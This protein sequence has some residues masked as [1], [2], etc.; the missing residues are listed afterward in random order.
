MKKSVTIFKIRLLYIMVVVAVLSTEVKAQLTTY[1]WPT[2]SGQADT[3]DKYSVFVKLGESGTE[4]K[5]EV[6]MSNAIYEGDWRA[7]ELQGRT[8]SFVNLAYNPANDTLFIRVVKEFGVAAT[9]ATI[10]PKSYDLFYNLDPSGKEVNLQVD[11]NNRY[12]SVHFAATDNKTSPHNWIKHMLVIAVDPLET[13]APEKTGTG[14]IE[15]SKSLDATTLQNAT[16]IYFPAGYHNLKDYENTGIIDAE[17]ILSLQN[18]QS[19]YIEGGAF[20]EGLINHPD[21]N[22]NG[23]KVYGRGIISGRQYPWD[24]KYGQIVNIGNNAMVEGVTIMESPFHGIVGRK[25]EIKNIKFLG[26]HSNNDGIRVGSGSEIYNSFLRCVDDH[27]YNFDIHV[28][29][30][31]LW[32]G[33]NG[34]IMTYG[35]GSYDAGSSIMEDIDIIHPEW[36]GIG[37]NNGLIMSQVAH[38]F[39]P[40]DYGNSLQ[41][42]LRNIRIEG[43]IPGIVNL[44]PRTS[45]NKEITALPVTYNNVGYLGELLLEN[46]QVEGQ[47]DKG[48]IFGTP[49][50]SS[51]KKKP[52]LVKNVQ[53]KDV[54]IA[55][56]AVTIDNWRNYFVI[57]TT[58]IVNIKFENDS[59]LTNVNYGAMAKYT[60]KIEAE[61]YT[62]MLGIQ[63][64]TTTDAGGGQNIG[65]IQNSDWTS[66]TVTIPEDG[67]YEFSVRAASGS[68]GGNIVTYVDG[69]EVATV[70]VEDAQTNGWQDWYTTTPVDI[71]LDDGDIELKLEFTGGSGFLFN[72][73]WFQFVLFT[74]THT[75]KFNINESVNIYPNPVQDVLHVLGDVTLQSV[76]IYSINGKLM[77]TQVATGKDISVDFLSPGMYILQMNTGEEIISQKFIKK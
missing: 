60:L 43:S 7:D 36:I 35:W 11:T 10:A 32:A 22:D 41:T 70:T 66:Y 12:F 30:V 76:N 62:D 52:F 69:D 72:L 42:V 54:V 67:T 44:K 77:H 71:D 13:N 68:A 8:F 21:Y 34:S 16:V 51:D 26:W 75:P 25:V 53:F 17:G 46:I 37:N 1:D 29:D 47:F 55:G 63:T 61:D 65:F 9:T 73:N 59:V 20:I 27:F 14:V 45:G 23:Q 28:H 56:N 2:E 40:K 74:N 6:L 15:Y 48:Y 18:G 58:T 31:V 4:Q 64:E 39:L 33:H 57:D 24:E 38:D 50:A 3:S 19:V 5:V 49:N